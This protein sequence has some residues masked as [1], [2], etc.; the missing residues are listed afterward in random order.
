MDCANGWRVPLV[1]PLPWTGYRRL[2]SSMA[3]QAAALETI[4]PTEKLSSVMTNGSVVEEMLHPA[5]FGP[6][7]PPK[8]LSP[9]AVLEFK[10]CPQSFLFQYLY[11]L[12]QPSNLAT[13]KGTMCHS[14]LE[15]LFDLEPDQRTLP[16]LHD[17]LRVAWAKVR[18]DSPHADL[19]QLPDG[20][21]NIDAEIEWGRSALKL[22]DNY[23]NDLEDP[24]QVTRPN[25][26]KR[27]VW[28]HT[29]L[30]QDPT[31]GVTSPTAQAQRYEQANAG[32]HTSSPP[33]FYMR[34]IVD[35]LD[36]VAT[37]T[38]TGVNG[39]AL[40]VIDYKTGKA[41]SLQYSKPVNDRI[42]EETFYQLKVYA[43]LLRENAARRE[44]PL[45]KAIVNPDTIRRDD[46]ASLDVRY[47]EL[48][49]LAEPATTWRYDL[50]ETAIERDAVLQEVH[51]DLS[52]VHHSILE[53]V[54]RQ[55]PKAFVGC[56]RS[57]CHCH[58]CRKLF[59]PGSVWAPSSS[60]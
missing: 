60:S 16:H 23:Y 18:L 53:L 51:Q 17:L 7:Q 52:Q 38:S 29:H 22:L 49:Y 9:S 2:R 57:F 59:E 5:K 1:S 4:P 15:A 24:Q 37:T 28:L 19:F 13:T 39:V 26:H 21:R 27:E 48:F 47:L 25:P 8:S 40:K 14:A 55:D 12:R 44:T 58:V 42:M 10:K 31:F 45:G 50:G 11:K 43:L 33:T 46:T 54:D 36:L 35:R 32:N 34:G 41:P 20:T 3:T 30:A 6:L 56:K